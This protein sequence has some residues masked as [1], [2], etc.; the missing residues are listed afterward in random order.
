MTL[1]WESNGE[2]SGEG[3]EVRWCPASRDDQLT[4]SVRTRGGVAVTAVRARDV[5]GG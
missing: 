2:V 1:R 4:L 3:R 5:S